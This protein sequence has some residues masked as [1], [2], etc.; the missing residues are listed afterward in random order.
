MYTGDIE[1]FKRYVDT[2]LIDYNNILQN[3]DKINEELHEFIESH[4][5]EYVSPIFNNVKQLDTLIT[6]VNDKR[7]FKR[8]VNQEPIM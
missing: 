1:I 7:F 4:K 6:R 2:T 8:W 5:D 3:N